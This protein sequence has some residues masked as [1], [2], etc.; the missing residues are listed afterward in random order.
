MYTV[1]INCP[2]FFLSP[3]FSFCWA[4]NNRLTQASGEG[5]VGG[6]LPRAPGRLGAPSPKNTKYIRMRHY[7]KEKFKNFFP[8]GPPR[9][10]FPG[11]HCGSRRARANYFLKNVLFVLHVA[12]DVEF[13]IGCLHDP[14]N[15]QQTSSKCI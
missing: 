13:V 5:Q 15:V 8:R 4:Y 6:K 3:T 7:K 2:V 14:A 12:T 11:M 1:T 10:C 9:E